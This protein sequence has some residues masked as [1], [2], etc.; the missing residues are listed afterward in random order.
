MMHTAVVVAADQ[1][2]AAGARLAADGL[3]AGDRVLMVHRGALD[4]AQLAVT[5]EAAGVDLRFR[6]GTIELVHVAGGPT[7]LADAA[8]RTRQ[9]GGGALR[10]ILVAATGSPASCLPEIDDDVAAVSC[11]IDTSRVGGTGLDVILRHDAVEVHGH[12]TELSSPADRVLAVDLLFGLLRRPEDVERAAA[13]AIALGIEATAVERIVGVHLRRIEDRRAL[14]ALRGELTAMRRVADT[15]RQRHAALRS[16]DE[17]LRAA[18]GDIGALLATAAAA[19]ASVVLLEDRNFHVL[20]WSNEPKR[21]P[22]DLAELLSSTRRTRLAE[23][24]RAGA[25][26]QVRLGTPSAG[27]RLIMRLGEREV[28]GY[29]SVL[30]PAA[31]DLADQWMSRLEAPLVAALRSERELGRVVVDLSG[32]LLSQLVSSSLDPAEALQ[33]ATH[34]R[35]RPGTQRR[36]AAVLWRDTEPIG[37]SETLRDS[38]QRAGFAAGVSNGV[39]ALLLDTE[40]ETMPRLLKWLHPEWDVAIGLGGT[41]TQPAEAARAFREAVWAARLAMSSQRQV[42]AFAELGI[43]RLL[44]PGAE[45]GDQAFEEPLRLLEQAEGIGFDP[46]K[47]L[48]AYLDCGGSPGVAARRLSLHV[49]SLR[50]RLERI[51]QLCGVDL[52]DPEQQFRLQL[53]LRLRQARNALRD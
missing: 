31:P 27:T 21:P 12:V 48:G 29:L 34:L 17:A 25:A 23:E 9:Y 19:T 50:Y 45:A 30:P 11:L 10:V 39:L 15:E 28:L 43:H 35:W 44:L 53:A 37:R 42:V 41:I 51:A 14:V 3:A 52:A 36:L 22:P 40:Q 2:P 16:S 1:L 5:L 18:D 6:S 24:L 33:T 49:N 20:R 38:A 46:L 47:T 7:S 32:S 8:A 13:R 4:S 26:T